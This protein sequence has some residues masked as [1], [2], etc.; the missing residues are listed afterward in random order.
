MNIEALATVFGFFAVYFTIRENIWCWFFGL[1]QVSL[2][3]YIFFIAKL[4]SDMVLHI[5][6]IFLQI[7]GWYSWKYSGNDNSVLIV[8]KI[9]NWAIWLALTVFG[10]LSLGLI[11][12]TQ[13]DAALPYPDAF[14]TSASLV[15]QYLMIK[16]KLGSWLFWIAVDVIAIGI[17]INKALYF[18]SIL[19]IAFLVMATIGYFAW[20]K[21]FKK[22]T[23]VKV[24]A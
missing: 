17:Y 14:T 5:I 16:K 2:Y 9:K 22:Q 4:Y 6:Y 12:D 3:T 23:E 11:M 21:S 7:W 19:Y 20:K 1:I 13:T 10:T 15:A 24:M 18:T 8:S